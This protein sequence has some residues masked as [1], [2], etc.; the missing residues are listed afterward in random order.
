MS[1]G[2]A[3]SESW[4]KVYRDLANVIG[5]EHTLALYEEYAGVQ[6]SLPMRLLSKECLEEQLVKKFNGTNLKQLA[7]E[8]RY[9]ER[10]LQRIIKNYEG[11]R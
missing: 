2:K 5:E 1:T 11:R 8:Y 6:L 3:E 9:T 10:H 7:K 4:H